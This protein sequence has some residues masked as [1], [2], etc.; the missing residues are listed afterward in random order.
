MS[1]ILP[2]GSSPAYTYGSSTSQSSDLQS[3]LGG[4]AGMLS[5]SPSDLQSAMKSGQSIASVAQSKGVSTDSITQYL[6]TQIQQQ[7]TA[8]GQQPLDQQT[9]DQAAN[10]I[11]SGQG[12]GHHHHGHHAGS[13]SSVSSSTSTATTESTDPFDSTSPSSV[14]LF[15]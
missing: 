5:M 2:L 7:R 3:V 6:E 8:N 10:R 14:N 9:L 1:S 4:V 13:S 15:A 12:H 11:V